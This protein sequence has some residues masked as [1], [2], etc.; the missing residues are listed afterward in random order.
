MPAQFTPAMGSCWRVTV[1]VSKRHSPLCTSVK[2]HLQTRIHKGQEAGSSGTEGLW[3]PCFGKAMTFP[4]EVVGGG[5]DHAHVARWNKKRQHFRDPQVRHF[6]GVLS[7]GAGHLIRLCS[8][9]LFS[10]SPQSGHHSLPLPSQ[11]QLAPAF[12]GLTLTMSPS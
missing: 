5:C 12:L 11:F 8:E 10:T 9:C 3:R 4:L 2:Q 1:A 7:L 6:L